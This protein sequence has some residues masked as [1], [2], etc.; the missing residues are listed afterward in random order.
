MKFIAKLK[1]KVIEGLAFSNTVS[2]SRTVFPLSYTLKIISTNEKTGF[3]KIDKK[4]SSSNTCYAVFDN[5]E[6][7]HES[8]IFKQKLLT[9]Q[10][11]YRSAE[12]V[13]DCYT[14]DSYRG[15]GIY[16]A[17]LN[18]ILFDYSGK[19]LIIYADDFNESSVK[20][21][22]KAGFRRLYRFKV[23][24]LLGLKVLVRRYED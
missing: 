2:S 9:R 13:G 21:I 4:K 22:I 7:I 5:G 10:L 1:P 11:G 14:L 20:G 17:V 6:L 24:R 15:K 16:T 12:T 18:R 23:V 3:A 19:Q 8:W